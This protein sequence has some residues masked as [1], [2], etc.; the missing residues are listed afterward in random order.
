[1]TEIYLYESREK[2]P[3]FEIGNEEMKE[4]ID[5]LTEI[6]LENLNKTPEQK[7]FGTKLKDVIQ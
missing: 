2:D 6:I 3:R 7:I 5:L 1:M 4:D